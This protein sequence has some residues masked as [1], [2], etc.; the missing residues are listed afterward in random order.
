M[1]K[2]LILIIVF[3]FMNI[4]YGGYERHLIYGKIEKRY[5]ENKKISQINTTTDIP[6]AC[7]ETKNI[8]VE[9]LHSKYNFSF[10]EQKRLNLI[11]SLLQS[12]IN[13]LENQAQ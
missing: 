4:I 7:Q 12:Q 2:H 9:I 8:I 13:Q 3:S 10:C 6:Q 11:V 1:K 5:Q